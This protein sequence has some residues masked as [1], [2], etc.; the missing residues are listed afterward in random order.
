MRAL[1]RNCAPLDVTEIEA[2]PGAR[3]APSDRFSDSSKAKIFQSRIVALG[4]AFVRRGDIHGK[5]LAV[6][7][8]V[9]RTFETCLPKAKEGLMRRGT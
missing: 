1:S 5:G 2:R 6:P 3:E 7:I 9:V 4:I 8:D